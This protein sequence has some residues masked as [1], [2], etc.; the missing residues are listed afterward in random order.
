MWIATNNLVPTSS[1]VLTFIGHKQTVWQKDKKTSNMIYR[2]LNALRSF[3]CNNFSYQ[4]LF[5]KFPSK[6]TLSKLYVSVWIGRYSNKN[7]NCFPDNSLKT[8]SGVIWVSFK[9][10][11]RE[12]LKGVQAYAI[13]KRFWSLLILFL[14]VASIWRKLLK[15]THTEERS[16][17]TNS[18][19][20]NIQLGS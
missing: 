6:N 10:S 9:G 14:S 17:H 5:S 15:T 12:K 3:S 1:A 18:E 20:C 4:Q 19:R 13:K 11:V 8:Y 16:V 7:S 2:L